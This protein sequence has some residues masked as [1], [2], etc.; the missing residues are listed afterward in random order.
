MLADWKSKTTPNLKIKGLVFMLRSIKRRAFFYLLGI[1]GHPVAVQHSLNQYLA[2]I[3][4]RTWMPP[5][6]IF[7][8][9]NTI[10]III[11]LD[12]PQVYFQTTPNE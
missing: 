12:L 4:E 6:P 2:A 1:L 10:Y 8:Y 9:Y 7:T 3:L 11:Y 5:L